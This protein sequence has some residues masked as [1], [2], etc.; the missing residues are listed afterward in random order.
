MLQDLDFGRLE[1]EFRNIAAGGE[2]IILCFHEGKVLLSR[3]SDD[4]LELPTLSRMTMWQTP[5]APRYLFRMQG[6][7]YFLWTAAAPVSPDGGFAYEAVRQLR[8]L[9]SKDICYAIMTGWHLFNWYRANRLCH[10]TRQQG[11]DAPLS[12]L[13]K[14]DLPPDQPRSYCGS[15]KR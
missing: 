14:Y 5:I 4:T 3:G 13:R 10:R 9:K 15:H 2:D 8:Q 12:Q 1:N 6:K 11:A 7:N